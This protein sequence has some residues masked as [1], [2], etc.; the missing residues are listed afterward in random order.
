MSHAAVT[1]LTDIVT[2]ALEQYGSR[3][4]VTTDQL[5]KFA[6]MIQ[7]I[8]YNKD[9][10][11]FV[12]YDQ[13]FT[14][15]IDVFVETSSSSYTAPIDSDIGLDVSGSTTGVVGT[16]LNYNTTNRINR[17]IIEPPDGTT[18]VTL[19][20]GETLTVVSGSA[21]TGAVVT[22]QDYTVSNGPYRMPGTETGQ[23]P[24]RKFIGVTQVTDKQMFH[25]PPNN[26]FDGYDDYGL[27]LNS[28][29]GRNQNFPY[30]F[31]IAKKEITLVSS[32][33]PEITTTTETFGESATV[34]NTSKLRW[35][36]YKNPP[37]ITDIGD[38]ANL[39]LPEQYR[40]EIMFKGISLLSDVATYGEAGTIR[41]LM[42][43]VCAR[44]WE[45]MRDQYQQYGRGSDYISHGDNFDIYG[46]GTQGASNRGTNGRGAS[47]L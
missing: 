9:V 30:R 24:F 20:A 35:I 2:L 15:G 8:A 21:C 37:A 33:P 32:T 45:D 22:G 7:Y 10:D 16:L 5:V 31:N 6:N 1:T 17:W 13:I 29:P 41:Q 12:E 34:L 11:A 14:L 44:F 36:Y 3:F 26:S 39:I 46:L 43:P 47:W 38:E 27:Y 19:V 25:V 40:Y 28:R 18:S 23:P 4:Q 42:E